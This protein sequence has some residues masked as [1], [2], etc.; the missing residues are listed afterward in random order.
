[1]FPSGIK[2]MKEEFNHIRAHRIEDLGR[3]REILGA[4]L[5]RTDIFKECV[6][7]HTVQPFLDRYSNLG[8][9][10][11]LHDEIRFLGED[12]DKIHSIAI[13]GNYEN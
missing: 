13:G 1:M 2:K 12:L 4:A 10:Q 9:L 11:E 6:S 5:E 8:M 7:K 3:I